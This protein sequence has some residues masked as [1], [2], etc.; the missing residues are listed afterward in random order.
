MK[1]IFTLFLV[2]SAFIS[3]KEKQINVSEEAALIQNEAVSAK[4]AQSSD[5]AK[6][7]YDLS[8]MN[9]NMVY[10]EVFNMM[11]DPE[12]YN[13]KV[14]KMKGTF[15]VYEKSPATGG[16]TYA[17]II[18]DALACCKQGIEFHY[19]FNG[20]EPE[21]GKE[22]TVTGAYVTAILPDDITYNYVKAESVEM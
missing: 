16:K 20:V 17:V 9:A 10:A 13:G 19:D 22:I 3:C 5:G 14:I 18:S 6:I 2:I 8:S 1:K 15:T 4:S 7:D 12:L 11:I 21:E